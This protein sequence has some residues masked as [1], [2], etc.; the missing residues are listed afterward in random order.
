MRPAV[1]V[2]AAADGVVGV[3]DGGVVAGA[4]VDD[5]GCAVEG[6]EDG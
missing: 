5:V 3:D 4:A 1:D 6:V 2:L